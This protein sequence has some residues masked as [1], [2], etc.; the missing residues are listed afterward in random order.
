MKK[1]LLSI[2]FL[3]GVSYAFL[4]ILPFI[5]TNRILE[6]Q[7]NERKNI[8]KYISNWD[9]YYDIKLYDESGPDLN[10]HETKYLGKKN[11]TFPY[12][13]KKISKTKSGKINYDVIKYSPPL[14]C[15]TQKSSRL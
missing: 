12:D 8:Q 6:A 1:E 4:N 10:Q 5:N 3:L 15:M 7:F 14:N 2:M 13:L 9:T 11:S